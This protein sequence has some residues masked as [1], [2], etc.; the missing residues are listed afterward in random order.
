MA[1]GTASTTMGVNVRRGGVTIDF[2]VWHGVIGAKIVGGGA[3]VCG[4]VTGLMVDG[5]MHRVDGY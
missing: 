2:P 4:N 1:N 5:V 3:G